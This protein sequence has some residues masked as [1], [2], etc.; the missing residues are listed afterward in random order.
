MARSVP[1]SL[2]GTTVGDVLGVDLHARKEGTVTPKGAGKGPL[3]QLTDGGGP[4][5]ALRWM[6]RGAEGLVS[7]ASPRGT[8]W[9]CAREEIG[10]VR[11]VS[12]ARRHWGRT[13]D[14]AATYR[15]ENGVGSGGNGQ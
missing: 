10:P 4:A 5:A 2:S 15:R 8:S 1:A 13:K 12:T 7:C 3:W 14:A 11:R 9:T 6:G